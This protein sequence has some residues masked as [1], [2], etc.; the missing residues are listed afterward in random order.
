MCDTGTVMKGSTL[1]FDSCH[2]PEFGIDMSLTTPETFDS[3]FESASTRKVNEMYI[4]DTLIKRYTHRPHH[5]LQRVRRTGMI[6]TTRRIH[7]VLVEHGRDLVCL[8]IVH[9]PRRPNDK[10]KSNKLHH[11]REMDHLVWTFFI[12]D[13]RM[14]RG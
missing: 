3:I 14:I 11:R 1:K 12:P 8:G 2:E 10:T 9:R 13:G 4:S 7:H 5:L 6:S